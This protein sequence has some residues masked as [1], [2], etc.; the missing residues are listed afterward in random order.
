MAPK[1]DNVSNVRGRI[2]CFTVF[3]FIV[4]VIYLGGCSSSEKLEQLLEE[5]SRLEIERD[6]LRQE[7]LVLKQ[8]WAALQ[9][10]DASAKLIHEVREELRMAE[11]YKSTT[12]KQLRSDIETI[13][14]LRS[15]ND[16]L[17][18]KNE[19]LSKAQTESQSKLAACERVI[20][21]AV[22]QRVRGHAYVGVGSRHWIREVCTGGGIIVLE[23][24]SVW[25][26]SALDRI[27]TML[28]LPTSK[29]M[30]LE[31]QRGIFPY[32]LVNT[33][34]GEKAEAKLIGQ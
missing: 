21:A 3:I 11:E 24:G 19:Q 2:C 29:I 17:K 15:Q 33:D 20:E 12:Q 31:N 5:K 26:I 34:D 8:D 1:R 6:A 9:N 27:T 25:E 32:L 13:E 16:E 28:W 4:P 18:G 14:W 22:S 23:D 30:V 7:L 10:Q